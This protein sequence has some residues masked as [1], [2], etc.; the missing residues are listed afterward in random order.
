[1]SKIANK[2]ISI[3]LLL[4]LNLVLA[5]ACTFTSA[6]DHNDVDIVGDLEVSFMI[7]CSTVL[8][9][10]G[11]FDNLSDSLQSLIPEDGYMLPK[12]TFLFEEGDSVITVLKKICAK[13]DIQLTTSGG[14]YV[15]SIGHLAEQM[16]INNLGGW[17]YKVNGEIALVGASEYILEDD[18]VIEW[19]YTCEPGDI[20]SDD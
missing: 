7:S 19:H 6:D 17:M 12:T 18:D 13:M 16:Y 15:S 10:E 2:V 11:A 1:M 3:I 20:R 4:A 14:D 9:T 5:A 8:D